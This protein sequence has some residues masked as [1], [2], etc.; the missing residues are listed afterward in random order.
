VEGTT[1]LVGVAAVLGLV[2]GSFANVVIARVPA[3]ASIVRPASACPACAAPIRPRDNVPV[4]SWV[5]LRGR[6]RACGWRI[7]SRYPLVELA[8]AGLLALVAWRIGWSPEL[9]AYL[10]FAW[11]LLVLSVIDLDHKR[12]P[13]RLTYPLT[14]VLAVLLVAAGLAGGDPGQALRALLGGVVAFAVLLALALINPRGMGLGDVKLAAFLGLG[15][16]FLGWDHLVLG[17]FAAFLLGGLVAVALLALRRRGRRDEIPFGP[18]L[19]AGSL[20]A[21][22]LGEPL[23]AA[24]LGA[25]GL[26]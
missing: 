1:T 26:G 23:I 18:W 8:S 15:L 20:V 24:Y 6:C 10:L 19:A 9:P 12:I 14:P 11:T 22:L 17:L 21:V 16:G 4:L 7:P 13:N 2:L 5:V 3:G 25:T